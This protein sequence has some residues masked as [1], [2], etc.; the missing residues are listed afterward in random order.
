MIQPF[1]RLPHAPENLCID[2]FDLT[3]STAEEVPFWLVLLAALEPP[4]ASLDGLVDLLETIAVTLRGTAVIDHGSLRHS[5]MEF[6]KPQIRFFDVVWPVLKRLALDLPSLFAPVLPALSLQ[7]KEVSLTRHQVGCLVV[8]QFLCTLTSPAWMTDGSPDFHIWYSANQ[9]HPK[10]VRAYLFSVFSYF[11]MLASESHSPLVHGGAVWPIKFLV[12]SV[13]HDYFQKN[14]LSQKL[15]ELKVIYV[16][17]DGTTSNIEDS[18]GIPCGATV[19]SANK[20]VGFGCTASQ[21]EMMVGSSPELCVAV[22]LVPTL[23]D[24]EVVIVQGA[25]AMLSMAGYG[26]TAHI[27]KVFDFEAPVSDHPSWRTRTVLF[28]DALELDSYD[29]GNVTPDLLPGN[30]DREL[31][32]A[33]S[34]FSWHDVQH[35]P[36]ERVVTGLWGCGS[37]H[38]NREIKTLIQWVAASLAGT[39]LHFVCT[40]KDQADFAANLRAFTA[41]GLEHGWTCAMIMRILHALNAAEPAAKNVFQ[42]IQ[43][44]YT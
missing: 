38:G 8:H 13:S 30:I 21:E 42:V 22:L 16:P 33:Y 11:D 29:T 25:Q 19:I 6:W 14:R 2:R 26:R 28:M 37:F 44:A 24:D 12:R 15:S 1:T 7:N 34:A 23:A 43:D 20:D 10:A 4:L 5:F 9:P 36:F 40:G 27:H 31:H 32:K 18:L 41:I 39:K 3:D 17:G 35:Q